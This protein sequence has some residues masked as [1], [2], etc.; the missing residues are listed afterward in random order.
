[1]KQS[2]TARIYRPTRLTKQNNQPE[3]MTNKNSTKYTGY[4]TDRKIV[5]ESKQQLFFVLVFITKRLKLIEL[6]FMFIYWYQHLHIHKKK[7]HVFK[8]C[9][10]NRK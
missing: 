5:Q 6:Q 7:L 2:E 9:Q 1:M 10:K 8:K 3:K 4:N